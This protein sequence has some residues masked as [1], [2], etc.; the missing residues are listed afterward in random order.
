MKDFFISYN[1][2]DK[3]WAE[4]VAWILEEAGYSVIIQAWDFRPGSNFALKMDEAVRGT[5]KT[6]AILSE[7][8]L[9]AEYTQP[10]WADAFAR[11]P[12][13]S[14]QILI[15]VRVRECK[16][17]GLLR[18]IIHIDLVGRSEEEAHRAIMEGLKERGKPDVAPAF[19]AMANT[20]AEP[21]AERVM[22]HAVEYPGTSAIDTTL[23]PESE[24]PWNVPTGIPLFTGREDILARI[25]Q[26]LTASGAAALAQRQAISGLG[27][28]GKTQTAIEYARRHRSRYQAVLWAV[29]ETRESLLSD[30]TAIASVLSLPEKNIQEQSLTVRAVKRWLET[31]TDW[32]LILDNADE[33]TIL[34]EFLPENSSGHILLTSRAQVFD[35]VGILSP[36]ELEEM[37]PDDARDFLLRRTGRSNLDSDEARALYNLAE[38]LDYLPLALEQAGAYIKELRSSFQDYLASYR[39]RGL[40]LLEKGHSV[41]KYRKSVRTT[42]SLNFQRVE[43]TSV[44]AADVLRVSAFLNPD[45]IPNELISQGS[46]DLGP[47]LS[48]AL[49]NVNADPLALDET[50]RPLIQY[51]LIH[52]NRSSKT[53]DI[54]RLVQAVLKDGMDEA[55]KHAWAERVVKAV[56][57]I[58]PDVDLIDV[59][60]WDRIERLLP[61]A[62]VCGELVKLY[63]LETLEA[64]HLLNLT[65][66][67]L[68]LRG[69]LPE[70]EPLYSESLAAREKI[71]GPEH[72]DVASS[73]HNQAWLFFDQG[74]YLEA[75]PLY[76]RA[77]T[78]RQNALG[79]ENVKVAET[80]GKLGTLY[81]ELGRY[82]ESAKLHQQAISIYE[83][84][85]GVD[86]P[87]VAMGL[88]GLGALYLE[89]GK[90]KD[91]ESILNRSRGII[92]KAFGIDHYETAHTLHDLAVVYVQQ[93]RLADA[94]PLILRSL[95]I[96][97]RVFGTN[98]PVIATGLCNLAFIYVSQQRYGAAETLLIRAL[99]IGEKGL[100]EAH[101]ETSYSLNRLAHLYTLQHRFD[102][103]ERLYSRALEIREKALGLNHPEVGR[104]LAGLG[105]LYLEQRKY[106]KGEPLLRRALSIFKKSLNSDHPTFVNAMYTHAALLRGMN[107]K[108]EAQVL[109]AQARKA[110]AKSG[111]KKPKK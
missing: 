106:S 47:A 110:Q 11:D 57:R 45:R 25:E 105:K 111:K 15:P 80:L 19:P 27:G 49:A 74:K 39:Q 54:H 69:R 3:A 28:I 14:Q 37:S 53:Y 52:R 64:S 81:T 38:E 36:I 6:I 56:A 23:S 20:T 4:W 107:R 85:F 13:G 31:N 98:Y 22:P 30:F 99:E 2:A 1:K 75:E 29:A 5:D 100:G 93:S 90:Y 66:R 42:W 91:S 63:N 51:S 9:S 12:R 32:L 92:E 61:H 71:L 102:E 101:P 68:H 82:P 70:A 108:G 103:A 79:A 43:Q 16:P 8:Y 78:I 94:E 73:L 86:H 72:P 7:A 67:Y 50:L 109:E 24:I 60:R 97:E 84:L 21:T 83:K 18:Q 40:D 55:V 58:F 48:A 95:E 59:S 10:E 26:T 41:G 17:E 35:N 76:L 62:Q 96:E 46:S 89:Q 65:G 87:K 104:T 33:P 77:L 34:E 44:A 88:R